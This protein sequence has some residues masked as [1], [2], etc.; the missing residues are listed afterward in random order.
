MIL[1]REVMRTIGCGAAVVA[2][3]FPYGFF[4]LV[5]IVTALAPSPAAST[6]R[7]SDAREVGLGVVLLF[8]GLVAA[9][10]ALVFIRGK[11]R[12]VSGLCSWLTGYRPCR[13]GRG[14]VVFGSLLLADLLGFVVVWLLWPAELTQVPAMTDSTGWGLARS[15]LL[16]GLGE[17]LLVLAFP[18]ILAREVL[19][20]S[21]RAR[22]GVV[23]SGI[24]VLVLFR[25][26]YH[27]YQGVDGTLTHLPWAVAAVLLYRW[28]GR[29]WPQIAAHTFYDCVGVLRDGGI[30]TQHAQWPVFIAGAVLPLL[31]GL[32]L[33]RSDDGEKPSIPR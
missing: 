25:L 10:V 7:V 16:G 12:R 13:R 3:L 5:S 20:E 23:V 27:L 14:C 19:P 29:V 9:S 17:E 30:I 24:T 11:G 21:V 15:F 26:S 28:S 32:A 1:G 8:V 6:A 33:M 4:G 31:A 2:L 18:I 22:R